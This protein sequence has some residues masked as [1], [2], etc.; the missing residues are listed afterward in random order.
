VLAAKHL[1]GFDRCDLIFE[2]VDR[3]LEI[4]LDRLAG[5]RPFDQH[6][7]IVDLLAKA[8]ALFDVFG[9]AALPLQRLLR[10]GL[11]VPEIRR[12]DLLFELG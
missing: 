2:R 5:L 4:G 6:T 1:L 12:R 3:T 9:E 7:E 10:L 11:V 8:V